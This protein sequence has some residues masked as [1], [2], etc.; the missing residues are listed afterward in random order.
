MSRLSLAVLVTAAALAWPGL[1]AAQGLVRGIEG[2]ASQG[3]ATGN[4][5]AGPV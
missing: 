1:A 2:G 4:R 5:A 3:A